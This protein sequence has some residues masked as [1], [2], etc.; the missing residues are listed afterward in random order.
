[1]SIGLIAVGALLALSRRRIEAR[2]DTRFAQLEGGIESHLA[3]LDHLANFIDLTVNA[4][5]A[6][7]ARMAALYSQI[8]DPV[9]AGVKQEL[10]TQLR[11]ALSPMANDGQSR[12]CPQASIRKR[13][14]MR[15][16]QRVA[17]ES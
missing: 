11:F 1:M 15:F 8:T 6:E 17:G 10:I 4:R 14:A 3:Q 9:F 16:S 12:R 13:N 7:L 5:Y 2:M